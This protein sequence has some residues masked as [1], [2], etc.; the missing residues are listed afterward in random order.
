M[1]RGRRPCPSPF[2]SVHGP[3]V[4]SATHSFPTRAISICRWPVRLS[5]ARA[6][7]GAAKPRRPWPAQ[8]APILSWNSRRMETPRP[9]DKE[10]LRVVR[11]PP[12]SL[13]IANAAICISF[14]P[15][16]CS[17]LDD[18]AMHR[19]CHALLSRGREGREGGAY[20]Y[21]YAYAGQLLCRILLPCTACTSD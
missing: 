21:A 14:S 3:W 17:A 12:A 2:Q 19:P 10:R 15:L 9:R 7:A 4:G 11:I 1:A 13:P 16:L 18:H 8:L 6:R 5:L 20:A